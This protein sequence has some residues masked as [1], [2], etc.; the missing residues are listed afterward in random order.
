ML[1]LSNYKMPKQ[2]KGLHEVENK[3]LAYRLE[4]KKII[5]NPFCIDLH[6]RLYIADA[7]FYST[8]WLYLTDKPNKLPF[9]Y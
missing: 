1:L 4:E 6:R 2:T 9:I 5:S 7:L 8:Y 3:L